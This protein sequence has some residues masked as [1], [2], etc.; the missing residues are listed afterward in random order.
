MSPAGVETEAARVG[1]EMALRRTIKA[2]GSAIPERGGA[3]NWLV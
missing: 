2:I 3:V 1:F